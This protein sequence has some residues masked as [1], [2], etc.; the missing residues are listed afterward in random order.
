MHP[1]SLLAWL[2]HSVVLLIQIVLGKTKL[3]VSFSFTDSERYAKD[4]SLSNS[5]PCNIFDI[6]DFNVGKPWIRFQ[7]LSSNPVFHLKVNSQSQSAIALPGNPMKISFNFPT[8]ASAC[9]IYSFEFS[10]DAFRFFSSW[11]E[12]FQLKSS[13]LKSGKT[14]VFAS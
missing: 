13:R 7:S 8:T 10:A 12:I 3:V 2:H 14:Q 11:M 9:R 5:S 6:S 4:K 1:L